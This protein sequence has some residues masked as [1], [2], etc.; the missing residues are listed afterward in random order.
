MQRISSGQ[1]HRRTRRNEG[2]DADVAGSRMREH[3]TSALQ[4]CDI[5]L[6]GFCNPADMHG[7]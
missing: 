1:F 6:C 5:Q 3:N 7:S 2:D 4:S